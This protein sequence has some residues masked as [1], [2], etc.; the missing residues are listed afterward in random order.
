MWLPILHQDFKG[1]TTVAS[2]SCWAVQCWLPKM[3]PGLKIA[4]KTTMN[5]FFLNQQFR[6]GAFPVVRRPASQKP[7]KTYC[8][9]SQPIRFA[10][11]LPIRP[12]F[13]LLYW[14]VS[15]NRYSSFAATL[16]EQ[17]MIHTIRVGVEFD[18]SSL[19]AV[20]FATHVDFAFRFPRKNCRRFNVM[21]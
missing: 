20:L 10:V 18:A 14:S 12:S 15:V 8:T 16:S 7:T 13:S 9:S 6:H 19:F 5:H 1:N 21:F 4:K 11:N 2:M 3:A 17:Q